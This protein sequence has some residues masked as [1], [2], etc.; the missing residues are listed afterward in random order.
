[1]TDQPSLFGA[2]ILEGPDKLHVLRDRALMCRKCDLHKTR[3]QVVYG[4]GCT[5]RPPIAFV[6]E[7]P[8][9][10]EDLKGKPFIGRAGEL[11]D[12]MI[13]SIGFTRDQVYICNSVNCRPPDNRKPEPAE[14]AACKE[15]LVIQPLIIVTLGATAGGA[16]TGTKKT[17]MGDLRGKWYDWEG[18]LVRATYHPAYLL[19][20]PK[21]KVDVRD[22]LQ[23]VLQRLKTMKE[24]V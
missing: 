5:N 18:I 20:E 23:L 11:L 19:R 12:G 1:M 7:A 3:T 13:K 16:V 14:I 4:V 9:A 17:S 15:H 24:F 21:K 6:G 10:N 2:E 8:G 22:D